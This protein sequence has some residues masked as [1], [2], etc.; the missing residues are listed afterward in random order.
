MFLTAILFGLVHPGSKLVMSQGLE[1]VPFCFLYL[2][3][4]WVAQ[5]PLVFAKGAWRVQSKRELGLLICLGFVGAGLQLTEFVGISQD[6]PVGVVSFLVYSHPIWTLFLSRWV[7]NEP[8]S[9]RS[10]TQVVLSLTGI[11]LI[12]GF[13]HTY[14][15]KAYLGPLAAGLCLSLWIT[16][17]NRAAKAGASP[18][19][20]SFYYDFFALIVMVFLLVRNGS[21][22]FV[23][24]MDFLSTPRH[25]LLMA[26][27]SILV[28]YL[29][30]L[31][32]YKG[33]K[34]VP[35]QYVGMILLLEPVISTFVSHLAWGEILTPTFVLGAFLILSHHLPKL[36][37]SLPSQLLRRALPLFLAILS[38]S[39][40]SAVHVIEIVPSSPS[41]YTVSQELNEIK[42]AARL[43]LTDYKQ[44]FPQCKASLN[45][46][47][48]YGS[49]DNLFQSVKALA[50]KPGAVLVGFSRTNFAR[51]AAK[52]L[53]GSSVT[54][55][56]VGAS[57]SDLRS[58]HP[59]FF[60]I[61]S[62]WDSQWTSLKTEINHRCSDRILGVF[63]LT[64]PISKEFQRVFTEQKT[65]K[66]VELSTL[67]ADYLSKALS[68]Q[69]CLFIALNFSQSS[70]LLNNLVQAKWKGNVFGIGD[71]N[72]FS[73][74]LEKT[75]SKAKYPGLTVSF[76]TG[77][78]REA[79]NKT[80]AFSERVRKSSGRLV[81]PLSAYT[82]DSVLVALH[83]ACTQVSVNKIFL[84]KELREYLLRQYH[85][86]SAGG[87]FLS[88]IYLVTKRSQS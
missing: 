23:Q 27:Y 12:S 70:D 18:T 52:A 8:I 74:E 45:E 50:K 41:D 83:S 67:S 11:F 49:E 5:I 1:L 21:D 31:L 4:R 13:D 6:L 81:S 7:N 53:S 37:F 42:I 2:L 17:S 43:A 48:S 54:A 26:T 32:F 51:L 55:I 84:K 72:Y 33:S 56:S 16:L 25:F 86:V 78:D 34:R 76:P 64:N 47:L 38:N 63:D 39:A 9:S 62:P 65:G 14:P 77:W 57:F 79:N 40:L 46:H 22:Q 59:R 19:C 80:R 85:G 28:G 68:N 3:I 44:N 24:A 75:L 87:N 35:A 29:P 36:D 73:P 71:W 10:L 58:I 15:I 20:L 66:A 88:P 82:Y 30:N 69:R 60:S 61:V